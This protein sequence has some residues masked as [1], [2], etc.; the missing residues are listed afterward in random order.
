VCSEL[1]P[2]PG[3]LQAGFIFFADLPKLRTLKISN[4]AFLYLG[5][6]EERRRE[7]EWEERRKEGGKKGGGKEGKREERKGEG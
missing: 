4:T 1:K 7:R 2:L 5:G 6:K 3:K